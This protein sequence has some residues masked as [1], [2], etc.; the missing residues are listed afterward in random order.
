MK[1]YVIGDIH[2]AYE[3]LVQILERA[4]LKKGDTL[5]FLG[6]Y[7]DGWSQSAE[8]IERLIQLKDE[9]NCIFIR[10]NHDVWCGDW[11]NKGHT[12]QGWQ[13]QGGQATIDSYMRNASHM[14]DD[15]HRK[16]F[17][18]LD[19]FYI[20][21]GNR[22]FVHGGYKS[23]KGL[24]HEVYQSDYYWDRDLFEIT[25]HRHNA[26]IKEDEGNPQSIRSY[27]HTEVFIGHTATVQYRRKPNGR[28]AFKKG[29]IG[30]TTPLNVDNLWNLDTGAGFIGKLTIMDV[31]TKQ[32]WQSDFVKDLYPSE[33]GR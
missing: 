14:V 23:R 3:A 9:Y 32:Y 1:T 31:D 16:F 27:R 6:D 33:N 10:G 28:I 18:E 4:P 17:R 30:V 24:G 2:G 15:R 19:N 12:V 11:L 29:R 5:I 25:M 26:G 8:V 22:G 21:K 7:V 20:D 13:Q